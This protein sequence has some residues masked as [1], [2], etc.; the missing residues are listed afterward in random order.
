MG[1]P[2][3]HPGDLGSLMRV[4]GPGLRLLQIVTGMHVL[5]NEVTYLCAVRLVEYSK[6]YIRSCD[7]SCCIMSHFTSHKQ[8]LM[9][10]RAS[11]HAP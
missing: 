4:R 6:H 9:T 7:M 8:L 1:L 2:S 5:E 11:Y 10:L 3:S